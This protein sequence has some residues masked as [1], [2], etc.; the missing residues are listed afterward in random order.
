MTVGVKVNLRF[1]S[2][3]SNGVRGVRMIAD[4]FC[5]FDRLRKGISSVDRMGDFNW[6]KPEKEISLGEDKKGCARCQ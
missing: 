1:R 5:N 3:H 6:R 2:C 4:V